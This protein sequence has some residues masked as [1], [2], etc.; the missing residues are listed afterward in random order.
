[1][2]EPVEA[3]LF[4]LGGVVIDIDFARIFAAW[5]KAGG[6]SAEEIRRRLVLDEMWQA[7][8]CG[9]ISDEAFFRHLRLTLDLALTHEQFVA[10]WNAIFV[11]EIAG[12]AALLKR[13]STVMPIYAFSNTNR[14]HELCWAAQFK[15]TLAP[16]RKIF[17]SSTIGLRKPDRDA[18][19]HVTEAIGVAPARVMLLDDLAE[20]VIGARA[21]GLQAKLIR[22]H[23][24]TA[25][26]VAAAL[27]DRILA[28]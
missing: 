5:G 2:N 10:G 27:G 16:F 26:A 6:V 14:A 17:V 18:F 4:D 19:A 28:Q 7:Y 15:D 3:L 8:E 13:A 23:A 25:A 20:N 22:T 1:M 12:I 9:R 24:D 11:G 21:A